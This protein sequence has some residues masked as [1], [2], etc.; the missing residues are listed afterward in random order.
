MD[1]NAFGENNNILLYS[2]VKTKRNGADL[3]ISIGRY[4]ER[5][6]EAMSYS[7]SSIVFFRLC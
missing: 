2:E 7:Y 6:N 3:H 5:A 4:K 1:V